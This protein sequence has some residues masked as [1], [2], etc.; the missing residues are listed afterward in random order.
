M[1][2]S[3]P[4]TPKLNSGLL[5]RRG[6]LTASGSALASLSVWDQLATARTQEASTPQETE[7]VETPVCRLRLDRKNGN[8]IG[9]AWK[10]PALEIIQE[11][12]LGENFRILLPRPGYEANYF[13]S[14]EQDVT[15]IDKTDNGVTCVYD[16]LRNVRETLGVSVRY[17]IRAV[18]KSL[19]FAIEVDN[20]TDLPLAEVLFG[21][22]GG[23]RGLANRLDTESLV[24]GWDTN[25]AATVFTDFRAGG[26]GGEIWG[27]AT[28][29]RDTP[30]QATCRWCGWSSSI[31]GPIWDSIM[32]ATIPNRD[33]RRF[34]LNFGLSR[35]ARRCPGITGQR[36]PMCQPGNL[37]GSPWAG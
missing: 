11:P 20:P 29:P 24:P 22:V 17:H 25:L 1:N 37:S 16:K 26:Y 13:V 14:S 6:F 27:F 30:I 7:D 33:C 18:D 21:I 28:M 32:R 15:R 12:R 19:E 4:K 8:L 23:N 36:Q 3:D 35:R 31:V 34:I 5:D 2:K 10:N 9:V